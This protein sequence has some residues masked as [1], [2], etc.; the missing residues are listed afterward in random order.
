MR[1]RVD[2]KIVVSWLG[3]VRVWFLL[4]LVLISLM[5]VNTFYT[6]V[7]R[8][9]KIMILSFIIFIKLCIMCVVRNKDRYPFLCKVW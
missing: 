9:Y 2:G 7:K 8:L 5:H 3:T 1:V 6:G 4:G